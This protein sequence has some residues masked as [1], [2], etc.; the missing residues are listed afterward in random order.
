MGSLPIVTAVIDKSIFVFDVDIEDG[1]L[2]D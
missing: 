1:S 2:K